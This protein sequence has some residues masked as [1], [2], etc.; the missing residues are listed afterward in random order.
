VDG[1]GNLRGVDGFGWRLR[2]TSVRLDG[3]DRAARAASHG[4]SERSKPEEK[5]EV[6]RIFMF[7]PEESRPTRQSH[8]RSPAED[9]QRTFRRASAY[10]ECGCT[11]GG[12][13]NNGKLAAARSTFGSTSTVSG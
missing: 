7:R 9:L 3:D 8:E 2:G 12:S 6:R 10:R 13:P 5:R 11:H 4:R 1:P